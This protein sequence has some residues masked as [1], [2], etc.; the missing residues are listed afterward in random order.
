MQY[1][2]NWRLFKAG[3]LLRGTDMKLGQIALSVGYDSE[4]AFCHAFKRVMHLTPGDHRSARGLP[5][6]RI[7]QE[8]SE[9]RAES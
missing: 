4:A 6:R 2:T 9:V 3:R 7:P 5:E 1:L 8:W